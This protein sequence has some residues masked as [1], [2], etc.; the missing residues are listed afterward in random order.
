MVGFIGALRRPGACG[1]GVLGPDQPAIPP[2]SAAPGM[3]ERKGVRPLGAESVT[4]SFSS[5]SSLGCLSLDA[6]VPPPLPDLAA[7]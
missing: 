2:L 7:M 5:Y 4:P 3:A 6:T 1:P